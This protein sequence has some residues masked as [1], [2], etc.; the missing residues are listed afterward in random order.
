MFKSLLVLTMIGAG[1]LLA[2][3]QAGRVWPPADAL[4]HLFPL[5]LVLGLV[6]AAVLLFITGR[7]RLWGLVAGLILLGATAPAYLAEGARHRNDR[8]KDADLRVVQFNTFK[9]NASP[10]LAAAWILRQGADVV[11]LEEAAEQGGRVRDA[12]G[13]A[14]PHAT[15]CVGRRMNCSTVIL[16]RMAPQASGG[17]AR[18]DPENRR[19]LSAA[20]ARFSWRGEPLTIVGVHLGRP[21]P[22]GDQREQV[23]ELARFLSGA[24]RDHVVMVGDFNQ[25]P[26]TF[27]MKR[28]DA[29]L[30]LRRVTGDQATWPVLGFTKGGFALRTPPLLAIDHVYL[31]SCWYRREIRRGPWIGS[32]HLPLTVDLNRKC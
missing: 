20:W 12:L 4:N 19:G 21:W 23:G 2:I 25:T 3:G 31:G 24:D 18:A 17:L 11:V 1:V 10:E 27:T 6:P 15:D 7:W 28:Q 9:G 32:D 8:R 26:W 5:W 14:Y 29:R 13:R 16:S 30:G 22:F